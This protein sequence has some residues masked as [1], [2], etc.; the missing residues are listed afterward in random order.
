M[1]L[2]LFISV[3]FV[4][5]LIWIVAML[6]SGG[7]WKRRQLGQRAKRLST[8]ASSPGRKKHTVLT[9]RTVAKVL[10]SASVLVIP[11]FLFLFLSSSPSPTAS[12]TLLLSNGSLPEEAWDPQAGLRPDFPSPFSSSFPF[13]SPFSSSSAEPTGPSNM[14]CASPVNGAVTLLW[15]NLSAWA[16]AATITSD[17]RWLNWAM[18]N[19]VFHFYRRERA[20]N[21]LGP[22]TLI[23]ALTEPAKK[24]SGFRLTGWR[25][26]AVGMLLL[27]GAPA[28]TILFGR[29]LPMVVFHGVVRP[30]L[31]AQRWW[32]GVHYW[33]TA[34]LRTR[35]LAQALHRAFENTITEATSAG[36]RFQPEFLDNARAQFRQQLADNALLTSFGR[37]LLS[38]AF[39]L[40]TALTKTAVLAWIVSGIAPYLDY[41]V[42][43]APVLRLWD[44]GVTPFR[45]VFMIL[46]FYFPRVAWAQPGEPSASWWQGLLSGLGT[47]VLGLVILLAVLWFFQRS[48]AEQR[49]EADERLERTIQRFNATISAHLERGAL[50]T[51]PAEPA[52]AST[53]IRREALRTGKSGEAGSSPSPDSPQTPRPPAARSDTLPMPFPDPSTPFRAPATSRPATAMTDKQREEHLKN[54]PKFIKA[55]SP[56][57]GASTSR[58]TEPTLKDVCALVDQII[59]FES[60]VARYFSNRNLER[61][62]TLVRPLLDYW[63]D[64][65]LRQAIDADI[66]TMDPDSRSR[67][68]IDEIYRLVI[69]LTVGMRVGTPTFWTELLFRLPCP[70]GQTIIVFL[71]RY[72][73][74]LSVAGVNPISATYMDIF[75][76]LCRRSFPGLYHFLMR[77]YP[78]PAG[79]DRW[80]DWSLFVSQVH[81]YDKLSPAQQNRMVADERSN[82]T[83]F[84][85]DDALLQIAL[86]APELRD[87]TFLGG[88]NGA[89]ARRPRE[90]N[91]ESPRGSRRNREADSESPRA[92]PRGNRSRNQ[93]PFTR[94]PDRQPS[95]APDGTR[96]W[97]CGRGRPAECKGGRTCTAPGYNSQWRSIFAYWHSP[98]DLFHGLADPTAFRRSLRPEQFELFKDFMTTDHAR[99]T[100]W[101]DT[102]ALV[103]ALGEAPAGGAL[104]RVRDH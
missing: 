87:A 14:L 21:L 48:L 96:C 69:R 29:I 40:A 11:F 18:I 79:G 44:P 15:Q 49:R 65:A 33:A 26:V 63:L 97:K 94:D 59:T 8:M 84:T 57:I 25:R 70:P 66:Q 95:K 32:T 67:I 43:A 103:A 68:S 17:G 72:E 24:G 85:T 73:R 71:R 76:W 77:D 101:R 88:S 82:P 52:A 75:A 23:L 19:L 61:D 3:P 45:L 104:G 38:C 56:L 53:P 4:A 91:P 60:E 74:Y 35:F 100:C 2:D 41:L 83:T 37:P 54:M 90:A 28:S 62:D 10:T 9:R 31:A 89:T 5:T 30:S 51:T 80:G 92:S 50:P 58:G 102:P 81:K 86:Q 13:P 78:T 47:V 98:E 39:L 22:C 93:Y 55:P 27:T 42:Y 16:W 46:L 64:P 1:Y 34:P 99:L 12:E 6:C 7:L 20:L 36:R